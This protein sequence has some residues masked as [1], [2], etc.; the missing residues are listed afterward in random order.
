MD[1]ESTLLLAIDVGERT[2]AMAQRVV[3]QIAQVL[4]P[5][6]APRCLPDGLRAYLT[7]VLTQYGQW[8][9][10]PHRHA[11]GPRPK[12][13][14]MPLPPL[15]YAQGVKTTRR[16]RLIAV[17]HRVVFGT[18]AAVDVTTRSV[19]PD[20]PRL[21]TAKHTEIIGVLG[22]GRMRQTLEADHSVLQ[23]GHPLSQL[24]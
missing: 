15:L 23:R 13:R 5:H 18:Q 17:K 8:V 1:P 16:R 24:S 9:Q 12:P 10:P 22:R 3:H 21:H 20:Y 19:C 7:A 6:C 14:W 2:L 4:A 11:K